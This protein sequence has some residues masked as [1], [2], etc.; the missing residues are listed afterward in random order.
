MMK[1]YYKNDDV[2]LGESDFV[3]YGLN[4][5]KLAFIGEFNDMDSIFDEIKEFWKLRDV[6]IPFFN[7][8]YIEGY[9]CIDFGS[10]S[11]FYYV[12]NEGSD[13]DNRNEDDSQKTEYALAGFSYEWDCKM[14]CGGRD[15]ELKKL[16]Y[17]ELTDGATLL[18]K[19]RINEYDENEP[20]LIF[21][22]EYNEKIIGTLKVDSFLEYIDQ[23]VES[24]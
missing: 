13:V 7:T 9:T 5:D 11:K 14:K 17:I 8:S 18:G 23:I 2:I 6:E 19:F 21:D 15:I 16:Y 20:T 10:H 4:V 3:D 22:L 12:I 1:L 24:A